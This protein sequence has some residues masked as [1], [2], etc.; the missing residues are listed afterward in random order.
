MREQALKKVSVTGGAAITLCKA[1]DIYGVSWYEDTILFG[2]GT[3]GILAVSEN[4]GTPEALFKPETGDIAD[5]P[6]MLPGG[7]AV[8]YAALKLP[9]WTSGTDRWDKADIVVYSCKIGKRMV[10]VHGGSAPRYVPTGHI[11]YALGTNLLMRPFD[12]KR[13]KVM[14][15]PTIILEGV[16]RSENAG[17]G[18]ANFAFS[19]DGTLVFI[20]SSSISSAADRGVLALVDRGGN[21]EVLGLPPGSYSFPRLSPNGKQLA[22]V[23]NDDGGTI[24]IYDLSGRSALRRL[25]LEGSNSFPVW[26]PDGKQLAFYSN[27]DNKPGIFVQAADGSSTAERLT[28]LPAATGGYIPN[29][30]SPDGKFLAFT[31]FMNDYSLWTVPLAGERKAQ[32]FMDLPS[33]V[34]AHAAFSPD[35]H[36]VA[37]MSGNVSTFNIYVQPLPKTGAARYQI[38]REGR[39]DVPVW[40]P[41]GKELF[42][43]EMNAESLV[44][45]PIQTQPTLSFG[46]PVPLPIERIIQPS[47]GR[48]YDIMPD[49]KR[50]LVKLRET[51]T[52]EQPHPVQQVNI[53]LT[54]LKN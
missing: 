30:W 34:E 13:L 1:G 4:G 10:L 2:Y 50:F 47:G 25:T 44:A 14:G 6:Q 20:T 15:G 53:V 45:V 52:Q 43:G 24:W 22:V 36:W 18:A 49:G 40:S 46:Q 35:G 51:Q 48:A 3:S 33:S 12:L 38:S 37:Y 28:G 39:Y 23:T 8:L 27:R 31:A 21:R 26:S 41:D 5:S 54:G 29:S 7:D 16:M 11:V 32:L 19:D 9:D 42:F 17:T